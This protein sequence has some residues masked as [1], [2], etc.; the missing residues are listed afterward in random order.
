MAKKNFRKRLKLISRE[1]DKAKVAEAVK[2]AEL[3]HTTFWK[4][5]K[6][7]RARPRVKNPSV[8]NPARKVV[9]DVSKIL[10]VWKNHFASLGTLVESEHFDKAHFECVKLRIDELTLSREIDD[11]SRER[12]SEKEVE[13]GIS[14]LNAGK[15]PG[16][17]GVT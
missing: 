10:E 15:A 12:I 5:L 9:H 8:K 1:Y 2:K 3:D 6:R 16:C 4:M 17:D 7:E 11:F 13:R 14:L